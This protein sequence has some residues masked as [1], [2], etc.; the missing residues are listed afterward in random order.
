MLSCLGAGTSP[1]SVRQ[2]Q[3][4]YLNRSPQVAALVETMPK[5]KR[6]K[7]VQ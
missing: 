7:Q 2:L 4:P 6:K 5:Q 3:V 1:A